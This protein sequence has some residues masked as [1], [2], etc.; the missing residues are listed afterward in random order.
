MLPVVLHKINKEGGVTLSKRR[1]FPEL[2]ELA[3]EMRKAKPTK[4]TTEELA[5]AVGYSP[6]GLS[7][8]ISGEHDIRMSLMKRITLFMNKRTGKTYSVSQLFE[9]D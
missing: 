8:I 6:S 7:K 2:A 5:N 4:I 9:L 3:G 1:K